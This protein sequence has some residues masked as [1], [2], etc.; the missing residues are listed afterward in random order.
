M[1]IYW[2]LRGLGGI[3]AIWRALTAKVA[4]HQLSGAF[5]GCSFHLDCALGSSNPGVLRRLQT[6]KRN[7]RPCSSGKESLVAWS[8]M[9]DPF[10][11]MI[12]MVGLA[13]LC[14]ML[15]PVTDRSGV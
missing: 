3:R 13:S 2:R 4:R 1:S 9:T 14:R 7:L 8:G 5:G 11:S 15:T 6:T 10:V 12:L